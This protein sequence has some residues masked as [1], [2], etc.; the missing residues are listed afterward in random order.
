MVEVIYSAGSRP[1][2]TMSGYRLVSRMQQLR[3][4]DDVEPR[5]R[6]PAS[7]RNDRLPRKWRPAPWHRITN[8]IGLPRHLD[9]LIDCQLAGDVP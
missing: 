4:E 2:L 3:M 6:A 9:G 5:R 8:R 1:E 7:C